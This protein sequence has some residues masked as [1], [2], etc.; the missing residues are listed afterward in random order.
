LRTPITRLKLRSELLDDDAAREE[1]HD[2]L[3]D[4]D[5]MVKSALQTVKDSDIHENIT[6][7]RLDALIGRMLRGAQLAGHQIGYTPAGLAVR[8]KPLA[9]KRAIGNLLDNALFYGGRADIATMERDAAVHIQ[10]RDHGPGVPPDQLAQLFDAHL[11][12]DHG[13][14]QNAAGLG[15][16]LGI[17]R[18]VVEANGGTLTLENHAEGGLVATIVLPSAAN[19]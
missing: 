18:G 3:D 5:M 11:R 16:G 8:A 4:L 6:G 9:L 1:F 15:L 14:A 19:S 7:V 12:L 10:I 2:D 17:A 13:R